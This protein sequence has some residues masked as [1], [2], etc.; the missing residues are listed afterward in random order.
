MPIAYDYKCY[1]CGKRKEA[2][3]GMTEEPLIKCECGER[4]T[5]LIGRGLPPIIQNANDKPRRD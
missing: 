3:H 4:M 1:A 2:V 5:K